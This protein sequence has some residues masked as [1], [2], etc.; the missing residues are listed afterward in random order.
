[1]TSVQL[2]IGIRG[3]GSVFFA[4]AGTS[5][6]AA[7]VVVDVLGAGTTLVAAMLAAM[8]MGRTRR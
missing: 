1:M 5:A 8:A 2:G 4:L 3:F 7:L 6:S